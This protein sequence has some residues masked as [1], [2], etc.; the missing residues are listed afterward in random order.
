MLKSIFN[1]KMSSTEARL[2]LFRSVDGKTKEEIE[3]LKTDYFK[4][5]PAITEREL[6]QA[7]NGWFIG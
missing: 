1:E 4:V 2:L 5:L 7:H 6:K 3:Q